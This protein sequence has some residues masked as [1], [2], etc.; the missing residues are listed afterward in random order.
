MKASGALYPRRK[1]IMTKAQIITTIKA[2]LAEYDDAC[3]Y[4][5]NRSVDRKISAKERKRAS[6]N[7]DAYVTRFVTV[8]QLYKQISQ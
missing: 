2:Q 1:Q 6:Q 8:E 3:K 5:L 7:F 4:W